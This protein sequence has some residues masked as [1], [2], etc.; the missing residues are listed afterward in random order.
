MD[1]FSLTY[2]QS[3]IQFSI[4]GRIPI[5]QAHN[6]DKMNNCFGRGGGKTTRSKYL[7]LHSWNTM[8]YDFLRKKKTLITIGLQQSY[9]LFLP[10]VAL[11]G[12]KPSNRPAPVTFIRDIPSS[13]TW[14]VV[15][16]TEA[17]MFLRNVATCDRYTMHKPRRL[18][19][20]L[21][22]LFSLLHRARW[23]RCKNNNNPTACTSVYLL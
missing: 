19:D 7:L 22:F 20:T 4:H 21:H 11:I 13:T 15:L 12:W 8:I 14:T 17:T 10:Y 9:P 23:L 16:N 3:L 6:G 18:S 5:T 2:Q 1:A